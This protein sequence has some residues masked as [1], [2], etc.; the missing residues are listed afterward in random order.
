MFTPSSSV[1]S[2]FLQDR[3]LLRPMKTP[4]PIVMPLFVSPFASSRQLSSITT[5]SPMRIL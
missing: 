4:L 2:P 5:S 1:M 3:M